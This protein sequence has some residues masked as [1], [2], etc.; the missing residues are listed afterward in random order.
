MAQ[1]TTFSLFHECAHSLSISLRFALFVSLLMLPGMASAQPTDWEEQLSTALQLQQ[2]HCPQEKIYVH[3]DRTMYEPGES[4]WLAGYLVGHDQLRSSALSDVM[5]VDLINPAGTV[6]RTISLGNMDDLYTGDFVIS[7]DWPGGV[8]QLRAYTNYLGNFGDDWVF[9]K[10]IIVQKQT[11]PNFLLTMEFEREAYGPGDAVR[12][13]LEARD[14]RGQYLIN[15]LLQAELKIDGQRLGTMEFQTNRVGTATIEMLL[16]EDLQSSDVSLSVRVEEG[17]LNGQITKRPSVVLDDIKLQFLP[18]GGDWVASLPT[19]IAFIAKDAFGEP[20]DVSGVITDAYGT[21]VMQ[22]RSLHDGLGSVQVPAGVHWP[23]TAELKEPIEGNRR[24]PIPNPIMGQWQMQLDYEGGSELELEVHSL[25]AEELRIAI[26]AAGHLS[27][28]TL[29]IEPGEQQFRLPVDEL[30]LGI[31]QVTVFDQAM[32][33][34][35]ERLVFLHADRQLDLTITANK[36]QYQPF[37]AVALEFSLADELGKPL[38]GQLSISVTDDRIHT[39]ADDKQPNIKAQLLLCSELRGEVHEPNFYFDPE[40]ELATEALDLL[41]MTQGWRRF[42]WRQLLQY[43]EEDWVA[44]VQHPAETY[45]VVGQVYYD[46]QWV[47]GAKISVAGRDYITQTDETGQFILPAGS[48]GPNPEVEARF[49]GMRGQQMLTAGMPVALSAPYQPGREV[50]PANR[51]LTDAWQDNVTNDLIGVVVQSEP[52][53]E[54]VPVQ[55]EMEIERQEQFMIADEEVALLDE[56]VVT[57]YGVSAKQNSAQLS[58]SVVPVQSVDG[59]SVDLDLKDRVAGLTIANPYHSRLQFYSSRVFYSPDYRQYQAD[60]PKPKD[61][62]STLYWN[63]KVTVSENGKGQV[64]FYAASA[65]STYRVIAEGFTSSEQLLHQETTFTVAPPVSIQT[66]VP[67]YA[68]FGDTLHLPIVVQNTTQEKQVA[69]IIAAS[70]ESSLNLIQSELPEH[71]ELAPGESQR[72]VTAWAVNGQ[73]AEVTL[74]LS[75]LGADW[76]SNTYY[77]ITLLSKG[78]PSQASLSGQ[79]KEAHYQLMINDPIPNSITAELQLFADLSGELLAGVESMLQEP[80]GCFEQTSSTNYPNI[81][82]LRYLQEQGQM[83]ESIRRRATELLQRGYNRLAGFEVPTGGFSL[84]G[85]GTGSP[86]LT[87][88]G[89]LQFYDLQEVWPHVDQDMLARTEAWLQ[90]Q[91][92]QRSFTGT[93]DDG[94]LIWALSRGGQRVYT[95]QLRILTQVAQQQGDPYQLALA[96]HLNQLYGR[97]DEAGE[98][99]KE[100]VAKFSS[101]AFAGNH[102]SPSLSHSQGQSVPVELSGW[103]VLNAIDQR[104][105]LPEI[106]PMVEF[107]SQH[108]SGGGRFGATPATVMALKALTAYERYQARPKTDGS[109]HVTINDVLVETIEYSRDAPA[110]IYLDGL[111]QY[112]A[113]G[114]NTIELSY[115]DSPH[116]LPYTMDIRWQTTVPN[117]HEQAPLQLVAQLMESN[118]AI[119]GNVRYQVAVRN[120][121]GET[122]YAP[123]VLV[124]LPAGLSW[125][126]HQLKELMDTNQF[127]YYELRD[128]YLVIYMEELTAGETR[129]LNFDL[130]ATVPGVYQAPAATAYLYYFDE[131]KTWV[132]GPSIHIQ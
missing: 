107:L 79:E 129:L 105:P 75:I 13:F 33:P 93:I 11:Q 88:F 113:E 78:F 30:P 43:Q 32:R 12:A 116:A 17:G 18:E 84:F 5:R 2:D 31:A 42:H 125:Q 94:Y 102:Q 44:E 26:R 114:S 109:L 36:E 74:G 86:V 63:P 29:Q 6:V 115:G 35:W 121:R 59:L 10:E 67:P 128:Q 91:L 8:Y 23:L 69:T 126:S 103:A 100:L 96:A 22:F 54:P 28:H 14:Q 55:Q 111:G 110:R 120:T 87:A 21:E 68:A 38:G 37:E 19:R 24:Y 101:D 4:I 27:S 106:A 60:Q 9:E 57:G 25:V 7:P 82:V 122:A 61:E 95:Q 89:L 48:V 123:M 51:T 112:F 49:R 40:E 83:E 50:M 64:E 70:S 52:M 3:T 45:Q 71:I 104:Y 132:A 97:S 99:T 130:I 108:R 98:L 34:N 56:V 119:S 16:P 85:H 39:L 118:V 15:S 58:A 73:P 66:T 62:R 20:A 47:S 90:E 76:E 117:N 72:Y 65:M 1:K 77:P 92:A 127:D 124:G 53:P 80:N 41:L 46:G 131:A 81:M